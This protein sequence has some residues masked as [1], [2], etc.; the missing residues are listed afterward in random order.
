[1][2]DALAIL[3]WLRLPERVNF[4]VALLAYRVLNGMAPR[5]VS[6]S[7]RSHRRPLRSSFTLQLHVPQFRLSTAGRRSFPVTAS[8][9]WSTLPDDV[10][11]APSVSSFRR[12]LETFLFHQ[13]FPDIIV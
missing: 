8:I 12:Q 13:S 1:M 11:S 4:K 7:T 10:Q 3:H 9:S 6:E 5:T 2:S